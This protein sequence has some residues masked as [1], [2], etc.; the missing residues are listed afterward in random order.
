VTRGTV[1]ITGASSGIGEATTRHLAS[2]GFEVLAGVRKD[3]DAE[4]LAGGA[5]KPIKIDV[6]DQ[7]SI[8]AAAASVTTPLAGLV[9]NAGVA[10]AGPL[11]YLP[12]AEIR[13]Q[14]EINVIGQIAVTQAFL[15]RIREG[16]GRI[17]NI[18]SIGGKFALPMAGPYAASKHAIEAISDSLRR[19]LRPWGIHVAAIEPGA[20]A[21]PIWD[22]GQETARELTHEMPPEVVERYGKLIET[23]QRETANLGTEGADP[24]EV[25]KAVAHALTASRPKTRYLVGRDAKMRARLVRVMPDRFMDSAVARALNWR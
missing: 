14:L 7:A 1:L 16:G 11:E 21:T 8:D 13:H 24:I 19:E 25:A 9:N 15:P 4:R 20:I 18:S 5:I 10:V 17:V 23:M 22:K 3:A 12:I 2:L 6:G